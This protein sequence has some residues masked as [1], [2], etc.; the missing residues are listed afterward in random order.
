MN[1]DARP[2]MKSRPDLGLNGVRK[3]LLIDRIGVSGMIR[4]FTGIYKPFRFKNQTQS[5][6]TYIHHQF[7]D[8]AE[9]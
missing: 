8:L 1:S 6:L 7:V 2:Y 3:G 4:K 9:P 5:K